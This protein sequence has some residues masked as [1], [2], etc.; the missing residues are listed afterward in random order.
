MLI[1]EYTFKLSH[2]NEFVIYEKYFRS[3]QLIPKHKGNFWQANTFTCSN[4]S[5]DLIN[6]FPD[7]S[8]LEY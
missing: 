7:L 1:N 4:Q 5:Q 6:I 8:D 2:L 3:S